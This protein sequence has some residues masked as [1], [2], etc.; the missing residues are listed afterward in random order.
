MLVEWLKN[1]KLCTKKFFMKNDLIKKII[2]L[3][4]V[5]FM[6]YYFLILQYKNKSFILIYH[7]VEPY[8][9]GYK[10]LYVSPEAFDRQMKFLYDRGYR[11]ISL[12]KMKHNIE[13]NS[14][15]PKTF[16]ITFDDGY[17]NNL[18]FAYPILKKYNFKATIFMTVNAIGK[19]FSYPYM[20][21]AQHMSVEDLKNIQDIFEIGS[22]T[23]SHPD[24]SQVDENIILAELKKSKHNLSEILGIEIKHFCYPFGK[25]FKDYE[26]VLSEL[27]YLTSC[28]TKNG[29]IDKNSNVYLLPRIEWKEISAMSV[30]DFFNK[31]DFYIKIFFGI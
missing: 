4:V 23:M 11:T 29:L 24:L 8:K 18:E 30:K 2:G 14:I 28:T 25:Y 15:I 12:E 6:V 26:K 16:S 21:E 17:K 10:S 5:F 9:G 13:K 7:R 22:H 1:M 3:T 20:P 19:K 31:L 27:G